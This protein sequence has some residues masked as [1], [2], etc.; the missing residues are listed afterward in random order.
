[1]LLLVYDRDNVRGDRMKISAHR[2]GGMVAFVLLL[3]AK[4]I[5]ITLLRRTST[6]TNCVYYSSKLQNIIHYIHTV[7]IIKAGKNKF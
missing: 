4:V 3:A 5:I 1:M 7:C 6:T 2:S